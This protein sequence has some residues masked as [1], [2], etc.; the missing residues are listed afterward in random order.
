[1]KMHW[2]VLAASA[3]I[4]MVSVAAQSVHAQ[5]K[6]SSSTLAKSR[7]SVAV[8]AERPTNVEGQPK[9]LPAGAAATR[10]A[11]GGARPGELCVHNN[12]GYYVDIFFDLNPV[13][14]VSPGGIACGWI[15]VG[16]HT[17]YARAPGTS[18]DTGVQSVY[19]TDGIDWTLN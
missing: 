19:T 14:T 5:A 2:R 12:T 3:A 16:T 6:S 7:G 17:V 1:M 4:V 8:K 15:G 11:M 9:A 18:L 13:G 10:G